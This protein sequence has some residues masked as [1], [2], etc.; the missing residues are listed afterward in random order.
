[1]DINIKKNSKWLIVLFGVPLLVLFAL[2]F[3][4]YKTMFFSPVTV[5][6]G[7]N[8]SV[9]SM[10]SD[11]DSSGYNIIYNKELAES[12]AAV[13]ERDADSYKATHL[14]TSSST[15]PSDL[16]LRNQIA[17]SKVLQGQLASDLGRLEKAN[18]ELLNSKSALDGM[19]Q[20]FSSKA[21]YQQSALARH[22][23][24][25]NALETDR[26]MPS[27]AEVNELITQLSKPRS[28]SNHGIPEKV[29]NNVQQSTGI[30]PEEIN[31]LMN[32]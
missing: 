22:D 21:A 7:A 24:I 28:G 3:F 17:T 20:D 12:V 32:K 16:D 2:S 13:V 27:E 14:D 25:E 5:W 19:N 29:L 4:H 11:G 10:F 23:A 30:S 8:M 26:E 31:E 18:K 9:H 15:L 6:H 1:M